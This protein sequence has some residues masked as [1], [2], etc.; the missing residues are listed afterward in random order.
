[1]NDKFDLHDERIVALEDM[2]T[3]T[4]TALQQTMQQLKL[5]NEWLESQTPEALAAAALRR[6]IAK[7]K[8][9]LA[10][11]DNM[12]KLLELENQ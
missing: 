9:I 3:N 4:I 12:L 1:M 8:E 2:T 7:K 5:R 6:E 11:K 10:D